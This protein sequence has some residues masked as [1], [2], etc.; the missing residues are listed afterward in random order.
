MLDLLAGSTMENT[1]EVRRREKEQGGEVK[2]K[3]RD[4]HA[5]RLLVRWRRRYGR[6]DYP[7]ALD[8]LPLPSLRVCT[9]TSYEARGCARV[10]GKSHGRDTA[11]DSKQAL[12]LHHQPKIPKRSSTRPIYPP[13]RCQLSTMAVLA[14]FYTLFF[15]L[16]TL[17]S[18]HN[19]QLKAHAR[20]CF[21]EQLHSDDKMTVTFQVGDREFGG[22]GNL[23]VDFW[24]CE[25]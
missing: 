8:E 14:I 1:Q 23:D 2:A 25:S 10:Q 17:T 11:P 6:P 4:P 21:H 13:R 18:A 5:E 9:G 20:E 15:A 22:S 16:V 24:V 3:T 12:C 19:I 7:D